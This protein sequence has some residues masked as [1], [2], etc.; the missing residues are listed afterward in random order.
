[1]LDS[2]DKEQPGAEPSASASEDLQSRGSIQYTTRIKPDVNNKRF[3]GEPGANH[4][5]PRTA[6]AKDHHADNHMPPIPP[7]LEENLRNDFPK[8]PGHRD[9]F[10]FKNNNNNYQF[11]AAAAS[12]QN[13]TLYAYPASSNHTAHGGNE[14]FHM[15]KVHYGSPR[16]MKTTPVYSYNVNNNNY[17]PVRQPTVP[18]FHVQQQPANVQLQMAGIADLHP[19]PVQMMFAAPKQQVAV[20]HGYRVQSG[21]RLPGNGARHSVVYKKPV[22]KM[23]NS[24]QPGAM[25][26]QPSQAHR[27]SA[28]PVPQLSPAFPGNFQLHQQPFVQQQQPFVQQQQQQPTTSMSQ[29]VSVSYS[30]SKHMQRPP[31]TVDGHA[32]IQSRQ[33]TFRQPSYRHQQ[34]FQGGFNPNTV[35]VEGG[36]KPIVH[37]NSD[38]SAVLQDRSDGDGESTAPVD[39]DDETS[40]VKVHHGKKMAKKLI[41]R[42]PAVKH[43]DDIAK[44]NDPQEQ[45]ADTMTTGSTAEDVENKIWTV[46]EELHTS[47]LKQTTEPIVL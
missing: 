37:P 5:D 46:P 36:F 31:Q 34:P 10:V 6:V 7:V 12:Q 33:E 21:K 17:R 13:V 16:P 25:Q 19:R 8:S 30:T 47:E 40:N 29:S 18:H 44:D 35:V 14:P 28:S 4:I 15:P 38:S 23:F 41:S 32:P 1:M 2:C 24:L 9:S 20:K 39:V 3:Y 27:G 45:Q 11:P 42:K 43:I 22:Y 26:L